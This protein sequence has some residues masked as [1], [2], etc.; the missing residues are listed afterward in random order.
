MK[1]SLLRKISAEIDYTFIDVDL[2][3]AHAHVATSLKDR[4]NSLL[5]Q[6]ITPG[7]PFWDDRTDYY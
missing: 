6:T 1:T 7:N 5:R 4:S 2:S 3:A